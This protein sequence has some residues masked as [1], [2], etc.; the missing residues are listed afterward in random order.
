MA[1]PHM[2]TQANSSKNACRPDKGKT[3]KAMRQMPCASRL[4]PTEHTQETVR[5][6]PALHVPLYTTLR[7]VWICT[8]CLIWQPG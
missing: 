6:F 8:S 7:M 4:R 1:L 5:G 2:R 3:R